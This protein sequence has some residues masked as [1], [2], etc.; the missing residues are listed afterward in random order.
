MSLAT[1]SV[2]GVFVLAALIVVFLKVRQSDLLGALIEKRRAS[3]RLVGR[4][5]YVESAEKI[6]VALSLTSDAIYYENPDLEASF[7]LDRLDEISYGDE[8][9]TGIDVPSGHRVLRLRS[10]G[11]S[12]EF[13]LDK[14]DAGK[15]ESALPPRTMGTAPAARAV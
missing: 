2:L 13:L 3:G 4:A 8:L 1:A 9:M 5:E 11:A 14:N 6:P 7:D 15:W 12:F 10:H